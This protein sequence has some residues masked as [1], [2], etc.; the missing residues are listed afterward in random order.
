MPLAFNLF[1]ATAEVSLQYFWSQ[2]RIVAIV[3]A[4][5]FDNSS[6]VTSL[7]KEHMWITLLT[8]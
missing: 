1:G 3:P 6:G 2:P 5:S 7:I 4:L 8:A